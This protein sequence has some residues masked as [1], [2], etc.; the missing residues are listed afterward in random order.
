M[1]EAL[2][3]ELKAL[4]EKNVGGMIDQLDENTKSKLA[5][6]IKLLPVERLMKKYEKPSEYVVA[7]NGWV[8]R[9]A[10]GVASVGVIMLIVVILLLN[11]SCGQKVD[12]V[13]IIKENVIVFVFVGV[14]EYLFFTNIAIKFIPAPPSLL[15]KTLIEKFKESLVENAN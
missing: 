8:K 5:T 15:V 6:Y 10:I 1:K 4:L 14:V 12:I 3:K 7:H 2:D 13:S 9:S 11:Y